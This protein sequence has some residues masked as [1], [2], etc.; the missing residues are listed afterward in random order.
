MKRFNLVGNTFTHLSGGNKGY[1]VHGKVSKHIEWVK[2]G[3]AANFYIDRTLAEAKVDN[4]EGLK[5]GWLLESKYITPQ[6]VD[7]VKIHT[8]SFLSCFAN[9]FTHNQELLS[10]SNKFKWVPAQGFWIKEPKIY[11]K[12]KHISM[13]SSNK[14][15]CEGHSKRLEWI[16]KLKNKVD[17]YGRGFNEILL[18][19][20]GLCD[21]MFSVAIENGQ[22]STY[23]TE[24][25]LDCFATGTVPIYL[26]A[27]DIGDH[28]NMDGI[29]DLEKINIDKL[30]PDDYYNRIDAIQDNLERCMKM[31]ILEDFIWE[32]YLEKQ[33]GV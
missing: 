28:F 15:M 8:D 9:I 27:P 1:S 29:I 23:F 26:G 31:E 20:E 10:L 32:N 19:E 25:I 24:K 2:E 3:G 4:R 18:K 7:N 22:Y 13:I 16:D 17:L 5:Y 6:I 21:Y 12:T 30:T 11:K 33:Y 14:N